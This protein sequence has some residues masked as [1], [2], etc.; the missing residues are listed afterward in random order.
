MNALG[1]LL[2]TALALPLVGCIEDRL[3]V[4]VFTQVH[5]DGTCTRRVEYRLER[6]DTDKGN[7]RVPIPPDDDPLRTMHRF[8]AG[9]AWRVRDEAENGL[10]V[11]VLEATLPSPNDADGDFHRARTR[12]S[13]PAR[14]AVSA[15]ADPGHAYYEYQEVFR[16]PASPV[17]GARLLSRLLFKRDGAFAEG[18]ARGLDDAGATPRSGDLRRAFR[19]LLADPFA[20]DVAALAERPIYGPRERRA[21]DEILEGLEARQEALGAR[22]SALAP[23]A[24]PDDVEAAIGAAVNGL[25]DDLLPEV[26]AA[27]LP[28]S[29]PERGATVRFRATLVMPEPILRANACA[30]GDTVIWE[31]EEED[32]FGRGFEMR[33]VAGAR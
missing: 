23:L 3:S 1:R 4:D 15:Y 31:F 9:D 28:L 21:L 19:E 14:N 18:F 30:A 33:A 22:I 8:P 24:R 13:P 29:L 26:E 25:A 27:G 20:R 17:A 32:L 5:G 2:A 10:H 11:L 6:V 16:D 12:R 7:A